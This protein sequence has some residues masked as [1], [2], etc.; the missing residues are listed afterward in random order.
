[1]R[2]SD[3]HPPTFQMPPIGVA[4]LKNHRQTARLLAD[5]NA[6]AN[7]RDERGRN[8]LCR[9]LGEEA[10]TWQLVDKVTYIL[11]EYKPEVNAQDVL[12]MAA[13]WV[14]CVVLMDFW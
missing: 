1:M 7:F 4:L 6:D 9:L 14:L 2:S 13:V 3:V 8:L 11:E 10:L 5:N 12:G